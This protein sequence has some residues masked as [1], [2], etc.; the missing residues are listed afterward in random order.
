M[1]IKF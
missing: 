1:M